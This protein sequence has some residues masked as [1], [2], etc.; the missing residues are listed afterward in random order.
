MPGAT[1]VELPGFPEVAVVAAVLQGV[2]DVLRSHVGQNDVA[3]LGLTPSG[4][5]VT[6]LVHLDLL[7]KLEIHL[8]AV[9]VFIGVPIPEI[10]IAGRRIGVLTVGLFRDLIQSPAAVT[11][12]LLELGELVVCPDADVAD[13]A[14]VG[15][16]TESVG[17]G[18]GRVAIGGYHADLRPVAAICVDFVGGAAVRAVDNRSCGVSDYAAET[19]AKYQGQNNRCEFETFLL[20]FEILL[21]RY[22]FYPLVLFPR[23][24]Y[25]HYTTSSLFCQ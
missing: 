19:Q 11:R 25:L 12:I 1:K 8:L 24:Y 16:A 9:A 22:N 5:A 6:V 18:H 2:L 20:H 7:D 3:V 13:G 4:V 14:S 21:L 17:V 10:G 23:R 15:I